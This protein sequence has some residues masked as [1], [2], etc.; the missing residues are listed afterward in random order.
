MA[1]FA[2]AVV[3]VT[4]VLLFDLQGCAADSTRVA[5]IG[6]GLF[7]VLLS[8]FFGCLICI[9]GRSSKFPK[10]VCLFGLLL[11]LLVFLLLLVS[12]KEGSTTVQ[13]N[14]YD[15]V[16]PAR[17]ALTVLIYVSFLVSFIALC[18]LFVTV[19]IFAVSMDERKGDRRLWR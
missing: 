12:P 19:P 13:A 17:I 6:V 7:F 5:G 10:V 4:L 18:K 2:T 16:F 14:E 8:A 1:P 9:V 3:C 11:P 15:T